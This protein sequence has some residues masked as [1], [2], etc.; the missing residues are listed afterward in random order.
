MRRISN[1]ILAL[2]IIVFTILYLSSNWYIINHVEVVV[3]TGN[4]VDIDQG[5]LTFCANNPPLLMPIGNQT[6]Q[7][8]DP[9]TYDANATDTDYVNLTYSDNASFFDID[10]I[11]GII[12]WTP[13]DSIENTWVGNFV[14]EICINDGVNCN[15][16]I[17]CE[18]MNLTVLPSSNPPNITSYT[19]TNLSINITE[20][21]NVTLQTFYQDWENM[22]NNSDDD[23]NLTT[24]WTLDGV[25]VKQWYNNNTDNYT[26]VADYLSAGSHNVTFVVNDSMDTDSMKWEINVANVNRY[27]A[28]NKTLPNQTWEEDRTLETFD[29]DDFVNDLDWLDPLDYLTYT[30]TF[31]AGSHNIRVKIDDSTH[32]VTFSQSANWY[33]EEIV[34]FTVTDA[35]GIFNHSNNVTLT[36]TDVPEPSPSTSP[37]GGGGGGGGGGSVKCTPQWYCSGWSAC[38]ENGTAYRDCY[39]LNEC[40][41]DKGKPYEWVPCN[42]TNICTNGVRDPEEDG[43]DCGGPCLPCDSC[44]DGIQNQGETGV[45]CGG[46]CGICSSTGAIETEVSCF[47]GIKNGNEEAVDCGGSCDVSCER[48]AFVSNREN[49]FDIWTMN[50]K[51]GA[52]R[53][54]TSTYGNEIN[55]SWSYDGDKIAFSSGDEI[56][57]TYIDAN[58][59]LRLTNDDIVD[60]APNWHP[61]NKRIIF[62]SMSQDFTTSLNVINIETRERYTIDTPHSASYAEYS[63]DGAYIAYEAY[64]SKEISSDES[65]LEID[66]EKSGGNFENV[67]SLQIGDGESLDSGDSGKIEINPGQ[68][69]S[70]SVVLGIDLSEFDDFVRLEGDEKQIALVQVG[71]ERITGRSILESKSQIYTMDLE[72]GSV[73]R[74]TRNVGKA[75][76]PVWSPDGLEIVYYVEKEVGSDIWIV[77]SDGTNP[78]QLTNSHDNDVFPSW[79]PDGRKIVFSSDED[80]DYDLYIMSKDGK[81][82]EKIFN[83]DWKNLDPTWGN[84]PTCFDNLKNGNEEG[85]DCGGSCSVCKTIEGP[86]EILSRVGAGMTSPILWLFLLVILLSV[87]IYNSTKEKV[88]GKLKSWKE[89]KKN[90]KIKKKITEE[91]QLAGKNLLFDLDK[92]DK[93]VSRV[94]KEYKGKETDAEYNEKILV[95]LSDLTELTKELFKKAFKLENEFTFEE[96]HTHIVENKVSPAVAKLVENYFEKLS[97]LM[98]SHKD[99]RKVTTGEMIALL[100]EFRIIV[101]KLA[102]MIQPTDKAKSSDFKKTLGEVV[103]S[104]LKGI[105]GALPKKSKK[106]LKKGDLGLED[107]KLDTLVEKTIKKQQSKIDID[108]NTSKGGETRVAPSGGFDAGSLAKSAIQEVKNKEQRVE[109]ERIANHLRLMVDTAKE[110]VDKGFIDEAKQY[111]E[112]AMELYNELSYEKQKQVYQIISEIYSIIMIAES[113]KLEPEEKEQS[114]DKKSGDG[115]Q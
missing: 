3:V 52:L 50:P 53:K 86:S 45:D 111:Y 12:N 98:Y 10:I 32:I 30:Y 16:S 64:L 85:V 74:I 22:N 21:E 73:K 41:V 13:P 81:N 105:E 20:E 112:R 103:F 113:N 8:G 29:L 40:H 39:D 67:D 89:R 102:G 57:V 11:T 47:D 95:L 43:V 48:I 107:S 5:F 26:Y 99:E 55:P 88:K 56:W 62:T 58:T 33:G 83:D 91:L 9:F 84:K 2:C 110:D 54:I 92:L 68:F 79:S 114:G 59:V 18:I 93:K 25:V 96:L 78:R 14:I 82:V 34:Y 44:S 80:G 28:F 35:W 100:H 38:Y 94:V 17:D 72:T 76:G 106:T 1:N 115:L 61:D 31:P 15:N 66:W 101:G 23:Q 37:S 19:P 6:A 46:P 104:R 24:M 70:G 87:I 77:N 51:G 36:V 109:E 108:R 4:A 27:V 97:G 90:V 69:L 60:F 49:S 42:A 7:E 75:K 63:P 71:M 65:L